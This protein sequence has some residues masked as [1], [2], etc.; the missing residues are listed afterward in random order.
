MKKDA[1][2]NQSRAK[3]LKTNDSHQIINTV[4]S[5]EAR[6]ESSEES[7]TTEKQQKIFN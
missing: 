7:D 1:S 2:H 6:S 5:D 4:V 3:T